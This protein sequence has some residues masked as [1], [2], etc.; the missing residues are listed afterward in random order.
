MEL[1]YSCSWTSYIS[2]EVHPYTEGEYIEEKT[3]TYI[4]LLS[5][6]IV[7]WLWVDKYMQW[8]I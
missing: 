6:T 5:F 1:S 8:H 7:L 3:W 4:V 2:I